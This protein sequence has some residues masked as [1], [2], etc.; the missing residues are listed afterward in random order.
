MTRRSERLTGWAAQ[1]VAQ[2][3][4]QSSGT[5]CCKAHNVPTPPLPATENRAEGVATALGGIQA[6][7]M[8]VGRHCCCPSARILRERQLDGVLYVDLVLLRAGVVT[9]MPVS[10]LSSAGSS[11][12]TVIQVAARGSHSLSLRAPQVPSCPVSW[13]SSCTDRVIGRLS[14]DQTGSCR[15]HQSRPLLSSCSDIGAASSVDCDRRCL[16]RT[17]FHGTC[18]EFMIEDAG[19]W[20][21]FNASL[22]RG[23]APC[24]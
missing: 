19:S 5:P 2:V 14:L 1:S 20:Y 3:V 21:T 18:P 12:S 22:K 4:L 8:P 7:A 10:V 16:R 23:S 17:R 6:A 24:W 13:S 11:L 15:L 9:V